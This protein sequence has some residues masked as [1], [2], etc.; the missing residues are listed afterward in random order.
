MT[1]GQIIEFCKNHKEEL[2]Q[3]WYNF[4]LIKENDEYFVADVHVHS[5][6]LKAVVVRFVNGDVWSA[7]FRLR[8]FVPQLDI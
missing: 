1:Q 6:G 2:G 8:V 4:F 5:D 7:E 3:N